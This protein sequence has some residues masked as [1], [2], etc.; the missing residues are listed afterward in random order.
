MARRAWTWRSSSLDAR[1][2]LHSCRFW[3]IRRLDVFV[4]D[5]GGIRDRC[6]AERRAGGACASRALCLLCAHTASQRR[7]RIWCSRDRSRTCLRLRARNSALRVRF[8][9]H[10]HR[11]RLPAFASNRVLERT[12][13]LCSDRPRIYSRHAENCSARSFAWSL[14]FRFQ[15]SPSRRTSRTA[16][17]L[18]SRSGHRTYRDLRGRSGKAAVVG[19]SRLGGIASTRCDRRITIPALTTA[20]ASFD[21]AGSEGHRLL[22]PLHPLRIQRRRAFIPRSAFTF[23]LRSKDSRLLLVVLLGVLRL[24][25]ALA[26]PGGQRDCAQIRLTATQRP[27]ASEQTPL[28]LFRQLSHSALVAGFGT[29][30]K[31]IR[32]SVAAPGAT[33]P[34]TSSTARARTRSRTLTTSTLRPS[35]SL[36][37]SDWRCCSRPCSP[38]SR[39]FAYARRHPLVPALA[40]AY[41]AF[42]AHMSVDWDWQ[43]TGV[44]LTGLFCGAGISSLRR[45]RTTDSA[46]CHRAF[47]RLARGDGVAIVVAF[48]VLVGNLSS[49]GR[50]RAANSW[51]LA[52]VGA[53]REKRAHTWAPWSSEPYRLLGEAQLGEGNTKAAADEF[54]PGRSRR[55]LTTGTSGSTLRARRSVDPARR[56]RHASKLNPLSPEIAELRRELAAEKVITVGS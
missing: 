35:P 24:R 7:N 10:R 32:S 54:P 9:R 38:R 47:A 13:H 12:R 19:T 26:P 55:A 28:Q 6:S 18:Q 15:F 48:V 3:G 52:S 1:R 27:R 42:L 50:P 21:Q 40:G 8:R 41:V 46:R 56:A 16:A 23:R 43:L 30:T 17:A 4:G 45:A 22:L 5:L 44:A 53:T 33:R 34:T 20:G 49:R 37:R 51:Q 2:P 11:Y 31:R 29:S 25:T 14:R 36:G 39:S